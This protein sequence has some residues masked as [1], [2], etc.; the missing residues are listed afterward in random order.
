MK[1]SGF[2]PG[3]AEVGYFL[4]SFC[5]RLKA[6]SKERGPLFFLM[7]LWLDAGAENSFSVSVI[8]L[9]SRKTLSSESRTEPDT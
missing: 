8:R 3:V 9:G 4:F 2:S 1:W 7:V 5:L 6:I